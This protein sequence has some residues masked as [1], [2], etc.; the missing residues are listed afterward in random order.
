MKRNSLSSAIIAG[1]VIGSSHGGVEDI[2]LAQKAG[3]VD[4]GAIDGCS[5][6]TDL[7]YKC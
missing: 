5:D 6:G 3:W 2:G 4:K 1:I 7:L